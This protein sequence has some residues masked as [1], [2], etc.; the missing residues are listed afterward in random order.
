MSEEI[1][2]ILRQAAALGQKYGARR[3]VLFGSRARGDFKERSDIDLA[4]WEM[5]ERSRGMF[6]AELEEL[7]TLLKFDICHIS[8]LTDKAFLKN[9]ERDGLTLYEE[10]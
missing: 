1:E 6:W 5:P 2:S 3:L 8:P 10:S 7:P 4:V 9:I